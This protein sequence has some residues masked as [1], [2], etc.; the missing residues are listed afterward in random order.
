MAGQWGTFKT[1]VAF[2]L[3]ASVMSG[4]PFVEFPVDRPG[5]VLLSPVRDRARSCP[6]CAR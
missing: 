4:K 5:G 2:D 3:A 1:F 6:G